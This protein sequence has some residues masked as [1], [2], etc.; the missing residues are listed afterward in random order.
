MNSET[1]IGLILFGEVFVLLYLVSVR[2]SNAADACRYGEGQRHITVEYSNGRDWQEKSPDPGQV[3]TWCGEAL[4]NRQVR[5]V[6]IVS[7]NGAQ[8]YTRYDRSEMRE[9]GA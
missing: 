1:L 8:E 4:G 9:A 2:L 5:C 7:A 3:Q 6:K